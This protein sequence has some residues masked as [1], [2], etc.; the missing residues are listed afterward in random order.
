MAN[1]WH[2]KELSYRIN[3]YCVLIG[4][5]CVETGTEGVNTRTE[6]STWGLEL[7]DYPPGEQIDNKYR[8]DHGQQC[9][10]YEA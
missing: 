4:Q 8:R 9:G 10:N 5:K 6:I 3:R 2:N 1:C 7:A